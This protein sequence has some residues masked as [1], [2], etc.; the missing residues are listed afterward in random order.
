M[1]GWIPREPLLRQE[2]LVGLIA[3]V[4]RSQLFELHD[5][6]VI[7]QYDDRSGDLSPW[8]WCVLILNLSNSHAS[9]L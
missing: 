5:K 3:R 6:P 4:E 8:S 2:K 7:L 9:R 1:V